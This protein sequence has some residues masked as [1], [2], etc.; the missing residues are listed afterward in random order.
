M[1]DTKI[2]VLIVDDSVFARKVVADNLKSSPD[3]E[4]IGIATNGIEGLAKAKTLHPDVITMDVEMPEL[5]G[6]STLKRVMAECPTPVLMLSSLT[7]GG[8][9]ESIQALRYGAVDIMAKPHGSHSIGL[10]LLRDELIAKVRAAAKVDVAKLAVSQPGPVKPKIRPT[11]FAG[12][13]APVVAIASSTGGPRALRTLIPGLTSDAGVAYVVVQH[14]PE[15]F[16]GPLAQD[17]NNTTDLNVRESEDGDTLK[18]GDLIFAKAGYHCVFDKTG[19]ISLVKSPPLWGVRPSADV[20]MASLVPSYRSRMIGVVLTGMGRDGADGI[21][22]IKEAGGMTLSEHESSCV[23]YGMPRV[24]FE[25]GCVDIV[26]PLQHM[27]EA[28]NAAVIKVSQG[29]SSRTGAA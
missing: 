17:L 24:A 19:K 21:R 18:P 4:V 13:Y 5:D 22:L 1:P 7:I 28:V 9:K 11:T 12:P 2:R 20:T 25:T 14:L 16:S 29:R 8:A 6:L 10:S 23:V 3:I 26:S 27:A 15:G